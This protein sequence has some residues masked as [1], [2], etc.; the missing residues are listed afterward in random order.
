MLIGQE[1]D[2]KA[3]EQIMIVKTLL[4]DDSYLSL[5]SMNFRDTENDYSRN[6]R[7]HCS[8]SARLVC[9][10]NQ[11][12]IPGMDVNNIVKLTDKVREFLS[13]SNENS[14]QEKNQFVDNAHV[15]LAIL[16]TNCFG[17]KLLD[18][19]KIEHQD[20]VDFSGQHGDTP[21]IQNI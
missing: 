12:Y 7:S 8:I 5:T 21:V 11:P 2:V 20:L 1:R 14:K 13:I 6:H 4:R 19:F 16:N 18:Y 3:G 9:C 15:I 17:K 10:Y